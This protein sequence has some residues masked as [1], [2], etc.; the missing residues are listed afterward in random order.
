MDQSLKV[1]M[2]FKGAAH[3]QLK[4]SSCFR[5][6]LG[7]EHYLTLKMSVYYGLSM[8]VRVGVV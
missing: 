2:Y 1:F 6:G 7:L 5:L 3:L 8:G 4:A